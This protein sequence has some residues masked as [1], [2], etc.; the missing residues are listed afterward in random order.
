MTTN[1]DPQRDEQRKVV[2]VLSGTAGAKAAAKMGAAM[3][4]GST[5]V[6]PNVAVDPYAYRWRELRRRQA[7][8][9]YAA[10][11]CLIASAAGVCLLPSNITRFGVV[12]VAVA[13]MVPFVFALNSYPCP[14]CKKPF[15]ERS[16]EE[17]LDYF[18]RQCVHCGLMTGTSKV[19]AVA[20]PDEPKIQIIR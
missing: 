4:Q 7:R 13:L 1:R 18:A 20:T 15:F 5:E 2:S 17:R 14:R 3:L 9:L 19:A 16:D 8:A 11:G 10:A 6:T 12:I